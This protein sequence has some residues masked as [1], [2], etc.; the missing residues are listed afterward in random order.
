M[1]YVCGQFNSQIYLYTLNIPILY[2]QA[3][4]ALR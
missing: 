4:D 3:A 2:T 1:E